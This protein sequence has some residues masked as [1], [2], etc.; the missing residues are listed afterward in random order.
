MALTVW[1]LFLLIVSL[2]PVP[3]PKTHLPAD[4]L[5]HFIAYG[6]TA[7]LVMKH[8]VSI[9]RKAWLVISSILIAS[10]YG[11]LLEVLQGLTPYRQPSFGDVLANTAGAVVFALAYAAGT[12]KKSRDA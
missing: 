5:E 1:L 12:K 7:V 2:I 3:G 11:A 8:F 10:L 6:I 9:G 4:K